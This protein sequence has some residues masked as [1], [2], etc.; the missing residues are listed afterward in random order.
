MADGGVSLGIAAA[1]RLAEL[2]CCEIAP[3]L[4]DA[5][6]A[7]IEGEC[8]FEFAD[9]HR[10]FLA[11]GLPVNTPYMSEAGVFHTWEQP[12][13]EWR[14]GDPDDLHHQLG[15][16]VRG[17]LR[18]VEAGFQCCPAWGERPDDGETAMAVA[19]W[20]VDEAPRL[21]PVY[22]HRFLPAG[23]GTFGSPVLS[24]YGTDIIRYGV[25]LTDYVNQEFEE[26]RPGH[27]N[28]FPAKVTVPFWRDYL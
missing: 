2:D 27:P 5:E 18:E 7:R 1:R 20:E 4:T 26:P 22:G 23:R 14:D 24:V 8:G 21:I 13:P 15:W 16:P 11:A 19:R 25:D 17:V 6:F 9:D 3:G 10:A 12:W 28:G